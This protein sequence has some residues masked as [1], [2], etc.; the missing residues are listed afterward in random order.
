MFG[1]DIMIDSNLKCWLL[2][3]NSSPSL[4]TDYII[5]DLIK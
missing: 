5:D 4:E 3:I 1:F 2:E